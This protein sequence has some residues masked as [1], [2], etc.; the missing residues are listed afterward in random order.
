VELFEK[1][2]SV[3]DDAVLV[4]NNKKTLIYS[5]ASFKY[6]VLEPL[7]IY[8]FNLSDIFINFIDDSIKYN[9]ENLL[10]YVSLKKIDNELVSLII[11]NKISEI[12]TLSVVANF[13][14]NDDFYT[15]FVFKNKNNSS[16]ELTIDENE[17]RYRLLF[18][19]SPIGFFQF[20]KQG[21][22]T[23]CNNEF[24]RI[25]GSSKEALIG[26]NVLKRVENIGVVDALQTAI[27]GGIGIYEG[28]YLSVTGGNSVYIKGMFSAVYSRER[29]FLLGIGIIEDITKQ[30][31]DE[32]RIKTSQTKLNAI[33]QNASDS[34]LI[35]NL[36]GEIISINHAFSQLSGYET[37]EIIGKHIINIFASESITQKPLDFTS[38]DKGESKITDRWIKTKSGSIVHVEM[39]SKKI[40]DGN[41]ISIIRDLTER[42][43]AFLKIAEAKERTNAL[44]EVFPDLIFI[45]NENNKI[46]DYNT[47]SQHK[48]LSFSEYF[49]GKSIYDVLPEKVVRK[50][51]KFIEKLRETKEIQVYEYELEIEH[52]IEV[53]EARLVSLSDG[54]VLSVVRDIT[55]RKNTEQ[56]NY[57]L[58]QVVNLSTSCI[59][60]TDTEGVYEYV[61]PAFTQKTGY[62]LADVKNQTPRILKSKYHSDEFYEKLW[63]II[64]S[65][66]IW[67]GEIKNKKKDG[68]TYW[69]KSVISPIFDENGKISKFFSINEDITEKK[70]LI[71]DITIAKEL[72]ERSDRLKTSFLQNMSHEIRTP[73][74]GILG[75]AGLIGEEDENIETIKEYA[76]IISESGT[77]L[78][79]LINNLIEIS[80]IQT[81]NIKINTTTFSLNDL[82][83]SIHNAF[84]LEADIKGLKLEYE[85]GLSEKK[86]F[87]VTD[88]EILQ[89]IFIHLVENAIKYT[90][91]GSV[92]FGY[93]FE[94]NQFMFF[95]KDSGI[96]I[97]D[98]Q[99]DLIFDSFY[100]ATDDYI[101]DLQGSG[102]GLSIVK[103]LVTLLEGNIEVQANNKR[104][105]IFYF[106][107]NK[108]KSVNINSNNQLNN[109]INNKEKTILIAEDDQTSFIYLESIL[110]SYFSTI[111]H[112]RNGQ[113]AVDY[114]KN[115]DHIDMILMDIRMPFL[116]GLEATRQI[117]ALNP[118]IP[119]IV[120]T[121]YAFSTDEA[122]LF[123]AGCDAFI[124][125]PVNK[126]S[127][128]EKIKKL[129]KK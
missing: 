4:V 90:K 58:S 89:Q 71:E 82:I 50:T 45:F 81:G 96:G 46:V 6:N 93:T 21:V 34:I 97:K 22:I 63:R 16:S 30:K 72:A 51:E 39:N 27:E 108:I 83:I 94:N 57:I 79:A 119:I 15:I 5:N 127:L 69:D 61:N 128:L 113:K 35:G 66:N 70:R 1:I 59:S 76:N 88:F 126:H 43:E 11:K 125:K 99:K 84:V 29:I 32:Q 25:I 14:F 124:T 80:Q 91:V 112:A 68:T 64:L 44:L 47:F 102:V 54:K 111:I 40:Y 110:N 31:K 129:C 103:A 12:L 104:G 106:N 92:I 52:K 8:E 100:K 118:Q 115:G 62:T 78:L 67:H 107:I 48:F 55:K 86:C 121:A 114:V 36:K 37:A 24:V 105:S 28:A 42:D 19:N 109:P 10:K 9:F 38:L 73:L 74:N 26:F 41:Y 116:N 98:S 3:L 122:E 33:F 13:E 2:Y 7:Q 60:V 117:K 49:L 101:I 85:I 65:G 23:D 17:K 95:V 20:N 18:E 120:Q 87:V 53:F 56:Q 75:F 77:R 123:D